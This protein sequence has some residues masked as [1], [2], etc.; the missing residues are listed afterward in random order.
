LLNPHD[1]ELTPDRLVEIRKQSGLE[2]AAWPEP[3][4]KE[5]TV[6]V[7]KLTEWLGMTEVGIKVFE[8][9]NWK[10]QLAAPTGLGIVRVVA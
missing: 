7:L 3:D 1:Q 8:D 4:P 2:E 10:G 9:V 6:T 5:R